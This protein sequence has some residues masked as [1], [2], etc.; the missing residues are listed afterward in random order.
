M[1]TYATTPTEQTDTEAPGTGHQ[2]CEYC[3]PSG[4]PNRTP[5]SICDCEPIER[6]VAGPA[7]IDEHFDT[8]LRAAET[9]IIDHWAAFWDDAITVT[10][11]IV[12]GQCND[13][14][15]VQIEFDGTITQ[16]LA[17]PHVTEVATARIQTMNGDGS[18]HVGITLTETENEE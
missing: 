16:N 15:T 1:S 9:A 6:N 13:E 14:Y 10:R 3:R 7:P 17:D 5:S 2:L 12:R 8:V 11:A 18:I 4:E